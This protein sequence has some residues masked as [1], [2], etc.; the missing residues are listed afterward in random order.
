MKDTYGVL[1]IAEGSPVLTKNGEIPIE[2]IK[3]GDYVLTEDGT[4]QKVLSHIA[5]GTAED[6]KI[7]TKFA[8]PTT[9]C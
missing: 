5:K 4:Y 9:K 2:S 6:V 8:H 1:C 3:E 7:H